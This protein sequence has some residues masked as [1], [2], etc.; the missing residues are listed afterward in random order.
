MKHLS[1]LLFALVCYT[2]PLLAQDFWEQL[3]FPDSTNIFS[4]AVNNKGDI[5]CGTGINGGTGGIYRSLDTGVTWEFLGMPDYV[6]HAL[7]IHDNGN[8]FAATYQSAEHSGIS[9]SVDNGQSWEPI[10]PDI[11]IHGNVVAVLPFGDTLFVSIGAGYATLVRSADNGQTWEQV[12]ATEN[13]NDFVTDIVKSANG[14]IF[15]SIEGYIQSTGGVYKSTDGGDNWEFTGLYNS[16]IS[17]L[18]MNASGDLFAGSWDG[19]EPNYS[20]VYVLRNGAQ[21]WEV[22]ISGPQ[23]NDLIVNSDNH[24]YCTSSWPNGVIRSLDNGENFELI[25]DGLPAGMMNEL[26]LDSLGFLYVTNPGT[27]ARSTNTTV[28][29]QEIYTLNAHLIQYPNP[30]N[31]VINIEIFFNEKPES[32]E[33]VIYNNIGELVISKECTLFKEN[34]D[35]IQIDVSDIKPGIYIITYIF[36][37]S[38]ISSKFIKY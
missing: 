15:I 37:K 16:M 24:I 27:L 31:D 2:S 20:G 13:S 21:D 12:F 29:V 25:I 26:I 17:S 22:L 36:S 9:K 18:A 11:G 14:E 1:L 10:I 8:I 23:I 32:F 19:Y 3:N 33:I 38:K 7:A 30:V 5:F 6:V 4:I 35:Q 28:S 34:Q